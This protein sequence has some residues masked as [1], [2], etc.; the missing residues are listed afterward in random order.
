MKQCPEHNG[1]PRRDH[2]E[3]GKE[4]EKNV[5]AIE[6]TTWEERLDDFVERAQKS[7]QY[8]GERGGRPHLA[9]ITD[10]RSLNY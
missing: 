2:H 9:S 5:A 8:Y 6:Y 1:Q 7:R 4:V 3:S 10:T